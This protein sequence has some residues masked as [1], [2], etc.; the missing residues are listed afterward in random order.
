MPGEITASVVIIPTWIRQR[1]QK[2]CFSGYG[3]R[4]DSQFGS[5]FGPYCS[6]YFP[7]IRN[8]NTRLTSGQRAAWSTTIGALSAGMSC[9]FMKHLSSKSVAET[10]GFG[11]STRSLAE[12]SDYFRDQKKLYVLPSEI[13]QD[14]RG[15]CYVC[16]SMQKFSILEQP[17]GVNWRETL[18]CPS[19]N[20]IN[21]WRSSMHVF[22]AL[23]TPARN[24]RLYL[25]E[26]VTP[27][28]QV[29]KQRYK[30][31]LGSEYVAERK[32]GEW[33]EASGSKI[34]VQDVTALSF[35][36]NEFDVLM[37]FDVLEHVPDYQAAIREFSRVLKP[38][39]WLIVSAPFAF[40]EKTM[41]RASIRPDGSI[42][43]HLPP[44]YHGDP[45]SNNG[46]LCFQNFGMDLLSLLDEAG[47][48]SASVLGF[49]DLDLGYLGENILFVGQ[50]KSCRS[51]SWDKIK[52]WL[53]FKD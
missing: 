14:L 47:I 53:G 28:Y 41:L 11:I 48:K 29:V 44:D 37:S 43:H 39:G 36:N 26:A 32:S 3:H 8:W 46:I 15:F 42:E 31:T 49:T 6:L 16:Q 30:N 25:T 24:C 13:P 5:D 7:L 20:L 17:D 51:E 10:L 27:L 52:R 9:L 4:V 19:C 22:E 35:E 38:G 40:A 21:R 23:C 33:A 1:I 50:K 34:L 12:L 2:S 45:F 18:C